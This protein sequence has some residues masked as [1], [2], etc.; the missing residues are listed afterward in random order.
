M[1]RSSSGGRCLGPG[2]QASDTSTMSSAYFVGLDLS[3]QAL[4][5]S[6]LDA[7]LRGVDEVSVRFDVDVPEFGTSGGVLRH[8][9]ALLDE[10]EAVAAPVDMYVAAMDVLW[11]RIAEK[12]PV[13]RIVALSA[14][15]QQHA[16][17]YWAQGATDLLRDVEAHA[18]LRPQ[19][20]GAF[21]RAI[22]PNWQ[23]AT[24]LDECAELMRW[25]DTTGGMCEVTGSM[26][27]TRFTAAQILRWRRRHPEQYA[28]TERIALVSNF[29]TTLLLA[30]GADARI[31]PLD[32][33]DACGMNL[34]D[35]RSRT[36][37]QPLLAMVDGAQA[38]ALEAKLGHVVLDPRVPVG[39]VG[40]WLQRRYGLASSCLVCQ[41]TGDNPATLQCLTPRMGEAV[42]SLGTSDTVLLPSQVY[43][44]D[45]TYHIFAHPVTT[46]EAHGTPPYFLMLVYKNGS[47]AR[48]WVR[49]TYAGGTWAGFDAALQSAAEPLQRGTGFF[50][51]R[52]EIIPLHARGL[53]RFNEHDEP[54]EAFE[55]A[56]YH[57]PAIVQ[58]QCLAFKTSIDRVL[59][60]SRTPLQRV[61][62]VG[63]AAENEHVCQLLADVLGCDVAR[64]RIVGR[65]AETGQRVPYNYCSVGAACRARWVWAVM[66]GEHAPFETCMTEA[67]G[68]ED[69]YDLVARPDPARTEAFAACV[70]RWTA[71]ASRA[72][73]EGIE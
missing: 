73:A 44:P 10:P 30:G 49:D 63:G 38:G 54:I 16:S 53:H 67:R 61:Y 47:L 14:A 4:K 46:G 59:R 68:G 70:P 5:A 1:L 45:P 23:D 19:L 56:T 3:T 50:W 24:T 7:S 72:Y 2:R 25:A 52:P 15:G 71:L 41:A 27:H 37:S 40:T 35:M 22:V 31:A 69:A 32:Q 36:W 12:W 33:S 29:V 18:P 8:G 55:D 60:T 43:T 51:L 39:R 17:V 9:H 62:V 11:D 42:I 28:R 57:V 64:P 21:S 34:W 6:L 20:A 65:S 48:E 58:S 13:D 66:Q 26:A